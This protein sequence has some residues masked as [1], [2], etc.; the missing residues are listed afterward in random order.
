MCAQLGY[1]SGT[2]YDATT[3][4]D[5]FSLDNV[6]CTGTER[7]IADCPHNAYGTENCTSPEGVGVTCAV[8]TEGQARVRAGTSRNRGRV[9]VLH[10]S[11]WTT[12]CD[13]IYTPALQANFVNV[14]CRNLGYPG[15]G[16]MYTAAGGADPILLDDVMC[17][18]SE[19]SVPMC[20]A[21][22]LFTNQLQPRRGHR[23]D[24]H[25]LIA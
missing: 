9:E 12:V 1:A 20:P 17:A 22:P 24:L 6:A 4:S 25:A 8:Y 19:S 15:T 5:V 21:L 3:P 10:A 14:A 7:R 11:I 18:G 16:S 2:I 13:D 23:R